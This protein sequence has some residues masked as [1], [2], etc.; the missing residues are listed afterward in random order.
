MLGTILLIDK[1]KGISSF[2][3]IRELRK[4]LG[5]KKI[6]H[7]GTLDPL[8]SGLMIVG[9]DEGTKELSKLIKLPKTYEVSVM[10]GESRTTGDLEG[11]VIEKVAVS[12][13][14]ESEVQK[15]LEGLKG[16]LK[17]AV[18]RYSAIKV[19]GERLYRRARRGEEFEP[20]IKEMEVI[21]VELKK[22]HKSDDVYVLDLVINVGSG[23]YI[24]SLALEI[25]K[26]LGY[27]ATVQALRRTKIGEFEIADAQKLDAIHKT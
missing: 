12:E 5:K 17:L 3:V 24:R 9:V 25:G 19:E 22:C 7:A 14:D 2:D 10:L 1:P 20:P 21:D 18:P 13:I 23:T 16:K 8:A 26:R 27:P 11:E 15:V 4:K 6:G